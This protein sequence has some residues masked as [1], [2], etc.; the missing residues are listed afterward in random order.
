MG[1]TLGDIRLE[2]EL[3]ATASKSVSGEG[4]TKGHVMTNTSGAGWHDATDEEDGP[5]AVALH[6][7][8]LVAATQVDI[9]IVHKGVVVVESTEAIK[10]GQYV[11]SAGT[12]KVKLE[13][14]DTYK[15]IVGR[16]IA[17]S[18]AVTNYVEILLG[19]V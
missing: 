19:G 6:T 3:M 16:A 4:V 7:V 12:G 8:A 5:F 17:N 10:E 11:V 13:S 1:F 15:R 14:A 18:E 9:T 2:F